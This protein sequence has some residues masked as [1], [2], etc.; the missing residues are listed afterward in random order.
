V[1]QFSRAI[2]R[3]LADDIL[4]T[5][6]GDEGPTNHQRLLTACERTITRLAHDRYHFAHPART[7]IRELRPYF[8]LAAQ[9]RM[10]AV[11]TQVLGHADA[12]VL[13]Q[14]A[15]GIDFDGKLLSCRALTRTGRPCQRPPLLRNGY[16]PSQQHLVEPP[17]PTTLVTSTP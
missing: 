2:Y 1:Y 11:V 9:P 5:E 3:E 17:T 10:C 12:F 15:S 16:C 4:D 14:L 7:L 6:P 8:P 13:R